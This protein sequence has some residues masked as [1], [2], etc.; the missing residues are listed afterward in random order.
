MSKRK[1]NLDGLT[2]LDSKHDEFMKYFS[3]QYNELPQLKEELDKLNNMDKDD[4]DVVNQINFLEN[5][6]NR[7]EN[8]EDEINYFMRVGDILFD[9]Y[10]D[11][12]SDSDENEEERR[13]IDTTKQIRLLDI[14][15]SSDTS[16]K[17]NLYEDF[18]ELV[19]SNSSTRINYNIN[20]LLCSSCNSDKTLFQ[21][22]GIIVCQKCG[23]TSSV[24][25]ESDKPNFKEIPQD[26]TNFS[27]RRINHLNEIMSQFQ[28]KEST[29]IPKDVYDKL[30]VE[31]KKNRISNLA[32][33]NPKKLKEYLHKLKLNKYYEHVPLILNK[34]NG[35]PPPIISRDVQE[36][37]RTMFKMSEDVFHKICPP[38]RKNF[39]SYNYF[40]HKSCELLNMPDFKKFFPLLKSRE[41]LAK[42]DKIWDQICKELGWQFY[43]SI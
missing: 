22:E 25:T 24:L 27:Y 15:K 30:L 39:I 26:N 13:V 18:L 10:A 40:L 14:V 2:T 28:G 12:K 32:L 5:K 21:S 6:I 37:I 38:S 29:D 41:K 7:I 8:N 3:S 33:L 9:Y 19:D 36:Q 4:I 31:I 16:K 35:L 20:S 11:N 1:L 17:A 34:L 43:R 23:S 42:T